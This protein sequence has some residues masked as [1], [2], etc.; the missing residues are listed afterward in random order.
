MLSEV[1]FV[2][3]NTKI[4]GSMT[5][6]RSQRNSVVNMIFLILPNKFTTKITAIR[7][8][9]GTEYFRNFYYRIF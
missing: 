7:I 1:A 4:P 2:M 8:F 5:S 9:Y 3:C 6:S